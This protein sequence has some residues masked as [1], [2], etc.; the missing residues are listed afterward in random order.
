M[1]R[2]IAFV[3]SVL[4]LVSAVAQPAFGTGGETARHA[5]RPAAMPPECDSATVLEPHIVPNWVFVMNFDVIQGTPPNQFPLGC[6]RVYRDPAP[7]PPTDFIT[8]PCKTEGMGP[9]LYS[10]GLAVFNGGYVICDVNIRAEL[11]SLVPPL[12]LSNVA[13]Y[14]YFELISSGTLTAAYPFPLLPYGNPLVFYEPYNAS[15]PPAGFFLTPQSVDSFM[16]T[17]AFNNITDTGQTILTG[18]LTRHE[19]V[20]KHAGLTIPFSV[21]HL[22]DNKVINSFSPRLPVVFWTNG[23]AFWFGGSPLGPPFAGTLDE[24][25]VDPPDGG[26]PPAF[27]SAVYGSNKGLAAS[28]P[29]PRPNAR[30]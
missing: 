21:T 17:S 23:G 5:S 27:L 2:K 8:V 16:M 10:G 4:L 20:T 12:S 6:I 13:H 7:Q 24:V 14:P 3:T 19:W 9:V 18:G 15:M 11:A 28:A 22:V 25:L 30:R 29:A 1:L 26:R